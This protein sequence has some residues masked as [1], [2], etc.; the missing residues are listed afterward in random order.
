MKNKS[1]DITWMIM[2]VMLVVM[3]VGLPAS[4]NDQQAVRGGSVIALTTLKLG[5][6]MR[7]VVKAS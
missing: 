4:Y 6:R 7:W 2:M 5:A 3:G 1:R